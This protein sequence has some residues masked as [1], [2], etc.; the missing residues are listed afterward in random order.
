MDSTKSF[1]KKLANRKGSSK[2]S[3]S[4]SVKFDSFGNPIKPPV[5]KQ[6]SIFDHHDGTKLSSLTDVELDGV[7]KNVAD[8]INTNQFQTMIAL[9]P[10][11]EIAVQA[12]TIQFRARIEKA[13]RIGKRLYKDFEAKFSKFNILS[14]ADEEIVLAYPELDKY[15]KTLQP[16]EVSTYKVSLD[17]AAQKKTV[18]TSNPDGKDYLKSV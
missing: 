16:P 7:L 5:S 3:Q 15:L 2:G 1:P 13:R 9:D 17:Q 10:L 8:F 18:I 4:T 14:L 12:K 11:I 6:D